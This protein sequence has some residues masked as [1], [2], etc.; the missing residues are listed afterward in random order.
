M[1]GLVSKVNSSGEIHC[2][3]FVAQQ[4]LLA[5]LFVNQINVILAISL[6]VLTKIEVKSF[7]NYWKFSYY[8]PVHNVCAHY[9]L[10]DPIVE[11]FADWKKEQTIKVMSPW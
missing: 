8:L 6:T 7:I 4:N 1:V 10:I 2:D 9:S 11:R 3:K 5:A